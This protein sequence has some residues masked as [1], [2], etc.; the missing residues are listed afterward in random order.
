MIAT[1]SYWSDL[2]PGQQIFG[3]YVFTGMAVM[4]TI[5]RYLR[6]K[7]RRGLSNSVDWQPKGE[8]SG[9]LYWT[10]IALG[11]HPIGII[12]GAVLWPIWLVAVLLL[13]FLK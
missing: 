5:Q 11:L 1:T 10:L 4:A 2:T 12:I 6:P 7:L 9:G 13:R 8:G 3:A